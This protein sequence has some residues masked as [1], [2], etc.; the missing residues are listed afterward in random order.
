MNTKILDDT[1][2]V[3]D[4]MFGGSAQAAIRRLSAIDPNK[5]LIAEI[6]DRQAIGKIIGMIKVYGTYQ[7]GF[8]GNSEEPGDSS[9]FLVEKVKIGEDWVY[10][11]DVLELC[12]I[13]VDENC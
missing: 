10:D 5:N 9:G 13:Y 7:N 12:Q 3:I 1:Q 11:S 2:R 4:E 8:K 6:D